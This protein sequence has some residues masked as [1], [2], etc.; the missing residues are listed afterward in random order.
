MFA[1]IQVVL[2]TSLVSYQ[3]SLKVNYLLQSESVDGAVLLLG[4]PGRARGTSCKPN[5][6]QADNADGSQEALNSV[7]V[8]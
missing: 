4:K 6:L 7:T 2:E 1:H 5:I 8:I 3:H